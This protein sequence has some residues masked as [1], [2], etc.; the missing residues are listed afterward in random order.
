VNT[1]MGYEAPIHKAHF[2]AVDR[3]PVRYI[4]L[5]QGHV[6]HVGGV[7]VFREDGTEIVAHANNPAQ[8]AYDARLATF[9]TRRAYFAFKA[10]IDR[11]AGTAAGP[12]RSSRGRNPRFSSRIDTHSRSAA[13]A[14]RRSRSRGAE[15]DDSLVLWLPDRRIV[16]AGNVFGALF[17]HFPNLVTIRGDRHR[18]ALRYV[19]AI[20]LLRDLEPELLLVGHFEPVRGRALVRAELDRIKGAVLY[21]HDAVVAA[22]NAGGDVWAANAVD[23]PAARSSRW[24][25][26]TAR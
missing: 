3:G 6:D 10:S 7:D 19:E 9:R 2:D 16:F 12:R 26:A 1:G 14:S 8:Q 13:F 17:G 15:T 11:K 22:M 18:D 20:D 23:P 21:V 4:V 5:T 25:R 24:G